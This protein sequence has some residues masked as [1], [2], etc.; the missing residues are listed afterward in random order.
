MA[1]W[2]GDRFAR[3]V[4]CGHGGQAHPLYVAKSWYSSAED[5][6]FN[7]FP[8]RAGLMRQRSYWTAITHR[9]CS[10]DSPKKFEGMIGR[11]SRTKY[12]MLIYERTSTLPILD[13]SQS[14]VTRGNGWR[15]A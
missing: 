11:F 5:S 15:A 2:N 14:C 4:V 8:R 6:K 9:S 1:E 12:M 13:S 3:Y 10:S 7:A